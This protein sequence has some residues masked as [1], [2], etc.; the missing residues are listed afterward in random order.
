VLDSEGGYKFL[1]SVTSIL[2]MMDS[3]H[4]IELEEEIG[5]EEFSKISQR[6]ALRGTAMH[7]FME[8]FLICMKK[9]N[10]PEMCLLYTQ[11]KSTDALLHEMEKDRVDLGRSLFYNIYHHEE[12][13]P[14]IKKIL[15]TERFLYSEKFLFAGTTD[16]AFLDINDYIVIADFKS[17]N[18]PRE[19]N[20]VKKYR[21]QVGAYAIAFEEIYN[22]PVHRGEIWISYPDGLQKVV[23]K[24]QELEKHK[25]EFIELAEKYHSMWDYT[26]FVEYVKLNFSQHD[27]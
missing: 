24:D 18:A 13:I 8:N 3:S 10:N 11:R 4:L 15:F 17:A 12:T 6:A 16:F 14:Q 9:E 27:I 20:T 25:L 2:S 7:L 23:V 21:N 1:P 22:K 19:E 5:K 26:P